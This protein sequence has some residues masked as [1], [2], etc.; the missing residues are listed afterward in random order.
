M[1]LRMSANP[2]PTLI[3]PQLGCN[4]ELRRGGPIS[5]AKGASKSESFSGGDIEEQIASVVKATGGWFNLILIILIVLVAVYQYKIYNM[6]CQ[7]KS[8]KDQN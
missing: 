6:V 1:A 4:D 7:M 8:K 5:V 2:M 3:T